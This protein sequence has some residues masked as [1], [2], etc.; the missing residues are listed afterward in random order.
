MLMGGVA[1]QTLIQNA[2]DSAMRARVMSLFVLISWG[3]PAFGALL[4][5]W[6]AEFFGLQ[7]TI[8]VGAALAALLWLWARRAG[9]RLAIDLERT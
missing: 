2:V 7:L 5:G 8:G 3:L 1:S 9:P 4:M 6:I